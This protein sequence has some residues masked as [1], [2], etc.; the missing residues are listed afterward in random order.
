MLKSLRIRHWIKNVVLF[1]APLFALEIQLPSL[2]KVLIGFFSFSFMASAFYLINDVLDAERDRH[3]PTKKYRPIASGEV[4]TPFALATATLLAAAS[5]GSAFVLHFNFGLILC[6]YVILQML[7]NWKLKQIVIFDIMTIA[8][9]FVLRALSGA[10]IV[11][12]PA[13]GW[14]LLCV[15]FLA[16]FIGVEKRKAELS[17]GSEYV[18]R[19]VLRDYNLGWL[20][21]MEQAATSAAIITYSLWTIESSQSKWFLLT[22]PI[23]V[24]VI[25]KFQEL[26][27]SEIAETPELVILNKPGILVAVIAWVVASLLILLATN[28][29]P[30]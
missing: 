19:P 24:Y 29:Y 28:G 9:G 17:S 14:F 20:G 27:E 23:V 30:A 8:I 21:K 5:L 6:A 12:V 7:Y 15:G 22:I 18:T 16:L 2:G 1:A 11:G 26:S 25:F 4:S 13:S 3:H 10:V